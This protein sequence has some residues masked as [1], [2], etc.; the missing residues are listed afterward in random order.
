MLTV[1]N[2]Y[3]V[4]FSHDTVRAEAAIHIEVE[5]YLNFKLVVDNTKKFCKW[6]VLYH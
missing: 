2:N 5:N 4:L 3:S 1:L 6:V